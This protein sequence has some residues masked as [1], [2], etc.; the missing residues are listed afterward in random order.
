MKPALCSLQAVWLQC[1]FKNSTLLPPLEF[2]SKIPVKSLAVKGHSNSERQPFHLTAYRE[3]SVFQT[4]PEQVLQLAPNPRS[5]QTFLIF[6]I[7]MDFIPLKEPKHWKKYIYCRRWYTPWLVVTAAIYNFAI[8]TKREQWVV[9]TIQILGGNMPGMKTEKEREITKIPQGWLD[10]IKSLHSTHFSD[11]N[12][13]ALDI[14]LS[15]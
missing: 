13:V 7:R 3:I 14:F 10:E 1:F 4:E 5:V 11:I 8:C 6:I 2:I 9:V 12:T 15:H